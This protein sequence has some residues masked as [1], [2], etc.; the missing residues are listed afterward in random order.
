MIKNFSTP[1]VKTMVVSGQSVL[2][3]FNRIEHLEGNNYVLYFVVDNNGE[4]QA[5]SNGKVVLTP[6]EFEQLVAEDVFFQE[7]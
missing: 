5:T 1:L 4:E 3:E 6:E 7:S 2:T